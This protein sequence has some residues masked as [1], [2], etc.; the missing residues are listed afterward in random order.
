LDSIL[1]SK[2]IKE[3]D[4]RSVKLY[5]HDRFCWTKTL[6]IATC[7]LLTWPARGHIHIGKVHQGENVGDSKAEEKDK[8]DMGRR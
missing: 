8:T 3:F 5:L 2:T 1:S 4:D 6:K 7:V